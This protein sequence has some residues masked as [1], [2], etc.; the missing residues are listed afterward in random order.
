MLS[1]ALPSLAAGLLGG[2]GLWILL[3]QRA[4]LQGTTL[5]APWWWALA[6]LLLISS[7]VAWIAVGGRAADGWTTHILYLAGTSS[8]CPLMAL[9]GAKRPQDGAWQFVVLTLWVVLLLPSGETL[10]Y[11]PGAMLRLHPARGWFLW[12]LIGLGLFNALPTRHWFSALLAVGGQVLLLWEQLP[13]ASNYFAAQP[14]VAL[15]L[16]VAALLIGSFNGRATRGLGDWN[17][18]WL[19]FRDSFGTLW[20]LRVAERFNAAALQYDWP[21]RLHWRGFVAAPDI[22]SAQS[23]APNAAMQVTLWGLL[24]RFVSSAW[25]RH[26]LDCTLIEANLD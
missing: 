1:A 3:R 2:L 25:V 18:V 19:D 12:I 15:A 9:L 6:S 21:V 5:V 11:H 7:A 10:L 14:L 8:F 4:D 16:F 20:S 24:R 22:E 17:R 13:I 26:R 23:I